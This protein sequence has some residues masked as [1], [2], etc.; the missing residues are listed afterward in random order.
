MNILQSEKLFKEAQKYIPG[1]VNSPVRAFKSVGGNPLFIKEGKGSKFFDADGNEYIDYIGSWGPHLFGHNPPF[2][3]EALNEAIKHGTSFGAP[4][5]IE[6]E[7]A[8]LITE[9]V[10]SVEKVRMVNSGTEATMSAVRAARG[11]TG[12]EKFIKFE[13][14]Y[15]GHAD[16]FLIKAGSGALTLGVPTSP[17]V[18]KGNAADTLLA[19]Y[20]NI[21]TIKDL[22]INNKNEIAAI[23]IEPIAGNMG[24]IKAEDNFINELRSICDEEKIVLIFDEVMTGFRVAKG[25]AQEILGIKPD[26]STF[27]K[28]I[29]G[30]LPVGAFGGKAEIM[31]KI[32]PVGPIYQAGTL[33]GNPLAMNAGFAALTYIKNNPNIYDILEKKSKYLADGFTNNL[34]K[35]G[36]KYAL[37]RVGSMMCMFFTEHEV[38]NFQ[39][40]IKSDTSLYG[41]Y[42]HNMLENGIY[43]APAQFEALFVSTAHSDEDL[44]KTIKAHFDS[45]SKIV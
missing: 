30:G 37:N 19:Q 18:T 11:Y 13:G 34:T 25:G 45:I 17:G 14:C 41:K 27:G 39:T 7:M 24:V 16:Y 36:K 43:L 28:I 2:I 33:S 32:A 8:K 4:T 21:N 9:L 29:G 38:I 6:I 12:R 10:P 42:F 22:I 31:D 3:I 44:D 40:A 15:H 1:G 5:E 26:L 20:N 35:I 23:I